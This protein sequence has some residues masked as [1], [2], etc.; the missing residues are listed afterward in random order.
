MARMPRIGGSP[1]CTTSSR[2]S[3]RRCSCT[4]MSSLGPPP[5]ASTQSVARSCATSLG[6]KSSTSNRVGPW[7]DPWVAMPRDTGF[8]RADVE[9]DFLRARRRQVL[10]QLAHR[11][12]REPDDVNLILSFAEVVA[13]LGYEGEHY[14]GLKTIKLVTVVGTVDSRRDFD[15]RF[16]PTSARVRERWERLSFAPRSGQSTPPL[17]VYLVY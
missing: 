17:A 7:A 15:R 4:P 12:R 2:G 13:A 8:P 16:R 5:T 14:L 10:A 3:T 6:A 11:L 9:N 1:L